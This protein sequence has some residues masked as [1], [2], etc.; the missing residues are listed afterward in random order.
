MLRYSCLVLDH[1]DTVVQSEA[2]V[3]YPAF[4]EMLAVFRPGQ[5]L[6]RE[7]FTLWCSQKGYTAM[8]MEHFGLT[9]EEMVLQYQ[10]WKDYVRVHVPPCYDGFPALL[11]RFRQ[12]GGIICVSS[13]SAVENITRDYQLHFGLLPD[14]IYSWDLPEEQRKPSPFSL[15]DIME[16]YHLSP[17]DLLMVDDLQPGYQM[18]KACGVDFACAAWEPRPEPVVE[19]MRQHSDYYLTEIQQLEAVLFA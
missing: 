18:A 13:H 7:E 1:D 6:T 5:T 17:K 3:N 10:Q 4:L 19:F 2:A 15:L 12:E 16:R 8:C 14:Q 11:R 9:Q